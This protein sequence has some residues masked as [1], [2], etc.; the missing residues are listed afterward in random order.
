MQEKKTTKLYSAQALAEF[1][2]EFESPTCQNLLKR[3]QRHLKF[4]LFSKIEFKAL[5]DEQCKW[6]D[7]FA[8]GVKNS[9]LQVEWLSPLH[10]RPDSSSR[11]ITG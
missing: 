11:S 2:N 8:A 9:P 6:L 5:G 7:K 1:M 10:N 3:L 4:E